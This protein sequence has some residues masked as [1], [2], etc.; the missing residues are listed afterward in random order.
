LEDV[1]DLVSVIVQSGCDDDHDL[2]INGVLVASEWDGFAGP[3]LFTD[4][5]ANLQPGKN[6][7]AIK[8]S[9]TAGGCRVMCVD[10]TIDIRFPDWLSTNPFSGTVPA[11]SSI[12]IQVNFNATGLQPGIYTTTLYLTSN[13]PLNP[14]VSIPVRMVVVSEGP[15]KF[16]IPLLAK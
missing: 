2:Y 13:D 7:M 3:D 8:A 10:T 11:N 12:P 16:Y 15:Y 6:V 5:K 14:L 1:T 4:I 9:D